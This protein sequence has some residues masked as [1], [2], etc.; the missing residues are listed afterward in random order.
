MRILVKANDLEAVSKKRIEYTLA[1]ISGHPLFNGNEIGLHISKPDAVIEYARN[2]RNL[3]NLK[4]FPLGFSYSRQTDLKLTDLRPVAVQSVSQDYYVGITTEAY[5]EQKEVKDL[6]FS[7]DVFESIFFHVSRYEELFA[8]ENKSSVKGWL[9]EE[10]HFLVRHALEKKPVV[11]ELILYLLSKIESITVKRKTSVTLSHDIDI[12]YR[13]YPLY[14]IPRSLIAI[15]IRQRGLRHLWLSCSLIFKWLLGIKKDPF[16]TF[17]FL[18]VKDV[19]NGLDKRVYLM[20]GG[21]T[22]YDNHYRINSKRGLK[23]IELCKKRKYRIGIHPS[24]DA[25]FDGKLFK[26]EKERLEMCS[27][28]IVKESRQHYLRWNWNKTPKILK[29]NK[30]V[31]DSSMGYNKRIGFRCGTGFEYHMYD[32][33]NE[34]AYEWK[35]LPLVFMESALIHEAKRTGRSVTEIAS[36]FMKVNAYNTHIEMNW[37]NSNF[38]EST[39]YGKELKELYCSLI[40]ETNLSA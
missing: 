35:E 37:H 15:I 40:K 32:F 11:D 25:G 29:E 36:D 9:E 20:T 26:D 19:N 22:R 8:Q 31:R 21:R 24:Y 13:F 5:S 16:D 7:F 30:I 28:G 27:G 10:N 6:C 14:K 39:H 34:Q 17:D 12:L 23:L 38:D 33:E 4:M 3:D 18:F 1:F 2:F